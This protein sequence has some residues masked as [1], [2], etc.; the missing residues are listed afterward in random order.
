M[1]RN[2]CESRLLY[3][4]GLA[5]FAGTVLLSVQA[6]WSQSAPTVDSA[7][8][9][10]AT[11]TITFSEE[12]TSA[13]SAVA[14]EFVVKLGE[15]S[16]TVSSATVSGTDVTLTLMESVPDVDCTE[17]DV[18]VSY[19][20]TDSSLVGTSGG[21]VEAFS[22]Q[23]VTNNTD[24][25]P[26]ILTIETD[27]TGQYV[28]V[29]FCEAIA[30]GSRR[31][32]TIEAFAVFID[33]AAESINNVLIRTDT[34]SRLIIQLGDRTA[35]GEGDSV[36][37]T[38][39]MDDADDGDPPQDANQGNKLVESWSAR[40]VTNN[41]D[42]PPTLQSVT[43]LYDIVTL[44]FSEALD[45]DSVPDADAFTIGGV[46]HAP[47]VSSVSIWGDTVTLTTSSILHN[48]SSPTWQISYSE[49]NQSP[50]RQLDGAHNVADISFHQFQ[51]STPT[52][53]PEVQVAEVDGST[54]TITFDLPLKAVAPAS[55]FAVSGEDGV[56]VSASSFSGSVVTLTLSPAVSSG[57]TIAVSYTV[58]DD[59]PRVEGRNNLDAESFSEQ[60]VT[61]NTAAPTPEFR[62]ASVSA[63]GTELTITFSLALDTSSDG[64]AD[65]STF[66]LSGTSASVES[67]SVN[68]SSVVLE[69]SP[70]VEV[71]ETITVS[72]A[73]PIG[74][75]DPRL[76]SLTHSKAVEAFTNESVTN[77]TDGKPR[78]LSATVDGDAVE[79]VFDREL[80]DQSEPAGSAFSIGG[81]TATVSGVAISG[82]SLTLTISP[83]VT[84]LDT[85]TVGYTS[86][87]DMPLERDGSSLLVDSFSGQAVT[88]NT[89][90]PTPTFGSA[91]VDPTG[92]T[93]TI[94]M[95]HPLLATSAGTPAASTFALSGGTLAEVESVS[96]SGSGVELTLDPAADINETVSAS[97]QPP[98]DTSEPALQ[99]PNGA[100]KSAA[101]SNESVTNHAD[102]VPRLLGGTANA[103]AITLRFDR[104]LDESSVPPESDFTITSTGTTVSNVAVDGTSVTLTLSAALAYDD[105]VTVSYS[106]AGSTKLK[107]VGQALN[108]AA[109]SAIEVANQTP[110][111]LLRSVVGDEDSIVLT[112][113]KTL[114]TSAMPDATAF[115]LGADQPTVTGVTVASLTVTLAL[116]RALAE[117]A[118]YTL[119]Y[120]VPTTS[121]LTT[122]DSSE[123]PAFSEAVTNHTDVAPT[124]L[125]TTGD[126]S[127]VTIE[128][129]QSLDATSMVATSLFSITAESAVSV[130]AVSFDDDALDLTLS[131]PLAEDESASIAYTEPTQD[132]L[133]DPSGNRTQTFM[134]TIDNQTDT[135]PVPV[136]GVVEDDMIT[137]V[138]DQEL[139]ADPRF[140]PLAE[141]S[142]VYDHFTLDGTDADVTEIE[143]SNGGPGGVGKIVLTLSEAVKE[144]DSITIHY[145]PGSGNIPIRDNDA[146]KNR[147]EINNYPL[148]NL[149]DEPPVVESAT[150]DGVTLL[151]TFDQELDAD[152][153]PAVTAFSLSDDGPAIASTSIEDE[154]LT[155]TLVSTAIEDVMYTLTYGRP[156]SGGLSDD[157]GNEVPAF[158]H[159]IDNQTDY[160][161]SLVS[162][163]TDDSGTY[164]YLR[165]DQRLDPSGTIG[166]SWFTVVPPIDI[167]EIAIDSDVPGDLQLRVT[168]KDPI[169][170]GATVT[171]TYTPPVSGGLRDDDAGNLV[172]TF[173]DMRVTNAV[174][175]EP[176]VASATLNGH[177]LEIEF[178]QLLAPDHKPPTCAELLALM[179]QIDDLDCRSHDDLPWFTVRVDGSQTVPIDEVQI[180]GST[181]RL[182]LRD[183]VG[184]GDSVT[185][186]Y[187]PTNTD[188]NEDRDLRD[189]TDPDHQVEG[190]AIPSTD[191]PRLTIT[192]VT[193]AAAV[194]ASFDRAQADEV[195]ITFDGDL[196][197]ASVVDPASFSVTAG[198]T[199]IAIQS[200]SGSETELSIRLTSE[201][202]ECASI[203]VDYQP[204][205][206]PLVDLDNRTIEAFRFDVA[207][208]IDSDWGLEC[209]RSDFG[210]LVL[211]FDE[212][213]VPDRMG[214]EW[215]LSV[216]GE[217]REVAVEAAG[218][219]IRLLPSESV[220]QGDSVEVRYSSADEVEALVLSRTIWQA[221]P[222]VVSAVADGVMLRVTFDG[223]LDD[224]LPDRL[225]FEATGG[226]G[227]EAIESIAGSVLTIHLTSPG[228]RAGQMSS[229][230]YSGSGLTDS[231]LTVG[232]FVVE[233]SDDTPA[234]ELESAY[235]VGASVFLNFDQALLSRD[236]PA[237]RFVL[238]GPELEQMVK[239]VSVGGSSVYLELDQPLLDEPD[240]FGLIYLAGAR[241]GLAGL[242]GSRVGDSVF[243]VQNYTETPPSVLSAVVDRLQLDVTFDQRIDANGA[244]PSDFSVVA[245]RRTIA[246]ESLEWSRSG[247]TLTLAERVTS[248]DA[249]ALVYSPGAGREV[250][251]TSKKSLAEFRFWAE[252][253]TPRPK[254]LQEKVDD[255]RLR[256]KGET[257][258]ERELA[259]GLA[260]GEGMRVSVA[261]GDGWTTAV[262]G[263]LKAMVDAGGVGADPTRISVAPID[264]LST[265][266]EQLSSI[267]PSCRNG[268]A[269]GG[270]SAWWVG[271]SDLRGVPTDLG[272]RVRLSGAF[273]AFHA[274]SVCVLDLISGDWR[275]YSAVGPIVGPALILIR[276]MPYG[277][278]WDRSPL[279]R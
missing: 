5:L 62:E 17:E 140:T 161:P 55:A 183:R 179:L 275:P 52:S 240:Q 3:A 273:D 39:D 134:L 186:R 132:G 175:V 277:F 149:N 38:Y 144:G 96:V 260:S 247:V 4:A 156:E 112:F 202:P 221:A 262:R 258:F 61:N 105:E 236:V 67:L 102:G 37:V 8:V 252:N 232:P 263:R 49:P 83:A 109:F 43:A 130:T 42:S 245:G 33:G 93:L 13:S 266:L 176:R 246:V 256:A 190:F 88:N 80:D 180:D 14:S 77:N 235:A 147:A 215:S 26:A 104:S 206:A 53:R 250:R 107:R 51:S 185:V 159:A 35:I 11:L 31:F 259:R 76:Q 6:A 238:A 274:V 150:V 187:Q 253:E 278:N 270:M 188:D 219:L 167:N 70:L 116:G 41:V 97:Y 99:S 208:L 211:T 47:S 54:L 64:L 166:T 231:G 103:D 169:R 133:A 98:S 21:T 195:L 239:T 279:A 7:I 56:A 213:G 18:T 126:G 111:P 207:N 123:L 264:D 74:A 157:S 72:Y 191:Y 10:G 255:A 68:G 85:I 261:A 201:V 230:S 113:T 193:P 224:A 177:V 32:L 121:P 151:V 118:V 197:N 94:V 143:I 171:L 225:D 27:I 137:I 223:S 138:L 131:R 210:G 127:T 267:P 154:V 114:D 209:V 198:G 173:E 146:G 86:P 23:A 101:W 73:P 57:S 48:Q 19:S 100:W 271:E 241:G 59:T 160:A 25:A 257:S 181:V 222:C 108:V 63:D 182:R 145:F 115:S 89:E 90:D 272:V 87:M 265:L 153:M 249:V 248:L 165:F 65:K 178:D 78:P 40:T 155:L 216:N 46:Q 251:D 268:E 1:I 139:F 12:L 233:I 95:S 24:D 158:V 212:S 142:V 229:L 234:P 110:E 214:F 194:D 122:S 220:C 135:A 120:T 136:S 170:E 82:K 2:S 196:G 269:G 254:T 79:I 58:P 243:L 125:S 174:D 163:T 226:V 66:S 20:P 237:S 50:L 199:E 242:T 44:T 124:A 228:L 9:D 192:N 168:L 15:E 204:G 217:E 227:V 128:F 29:T 119:T 22:E 129:D 75:L 162:I 34:P 16:Q 189:T 60:S 152:S 36:T 30:A 106:A 218:S 200:V 203:V 28:Y 92:R 117:G 81:V 164:I 45:E 205:S 244:L 71:N 148:E 184:I 141:D 172:A 84:H 69:L 276:E 91:S